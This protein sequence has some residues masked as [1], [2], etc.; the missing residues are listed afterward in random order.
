VLL[1]AGV[2]DLFCPEDEELLLSVP[3]LDTP[4]YAELA[5]LLG[6]LLL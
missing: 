4:E 3:L 6:L 5:S 1:Y 2:E